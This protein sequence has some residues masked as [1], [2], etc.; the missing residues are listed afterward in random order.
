MSRNLVKSTLILIIS[1]GIFFGFGYLLH[2]IL[3]R[4]LGPSPYGNYVF[5]MA[6]LIWFEI[7]LSSAIP[8]AVKKYTAE[9]ESNAPGVLQTGLRL[10]LA[11]GVLFMILMVLMAPL[12]SKIFGDKNLSGLII[13]AALDIPLYSLY[14]IFVGSINGGGRY[15]RLALLLS[16]Y[17][18]GKFVF[19]FFMVY[20]IGL[21]GAFIGNALASLIGSA[22][23]VM[24]CRQMLKIQS[25]FPV[26]KILKFSYPIIFFAL[27]SHLL[28][29]M[30]LFFIKLLIK[31][32]LEIGFYSMAV[33]LSRAPFLILLALVAILFPSLAR[34]IH[35]K[36]DKLSVH[37]ARQANRLY[38][39]I[40][41]PFLIMILVYS[42]IVIS[43][44]FSNRFL[45]GAAVLRILTIAFLFYG[46]YYLMT[47]IILA[48]NRP[49]LLLKVEILLIGVALMSNIILVPKWGLRGAACSFLITGII[50][51]GAGILLT[52]KKFGLLYDLKSM[53][54]IVLA[55]MVILVLMKFADLSVHSFTFGMAVLSL[56]YLILLLVIKEIKPEEIK[57]WLLPKRGDR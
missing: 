10:Q 1:Q 55:S 54:R 42:E 44:L 30:D 41:F 20:W 23:G 24:F 47:Y 4:F 57:F 9:N 2:F 7:S 16:T 15:V 25:V 37:Y 28:L 14:F 31:K 32:N 52:V 49:I 22:L 29:N 45:P 53:A 36:K 21:K 50:A 12:F 38:A 43:L 3:A 33:I 13:I 19:S 40:I 35:E 27:A 17:A 56:T 34:S 5:V 6:L 26:A 39:L 11:L 46:F 8:M 48:D 18:G 51:F